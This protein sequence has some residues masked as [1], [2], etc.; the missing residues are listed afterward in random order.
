MEQ[1]L[2]VNITL[3]CKVQVS[4]SFLSIS[5][6]K[7]LVMKYMR[8]ED[9]CFRDLYKF[10]QGYLFEGVT[11]AIHYMTKRVSIVL[12]IMQKGPNNGFN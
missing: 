6:S 4:A 8:R 5:Q 12:A 11:T 2:V 10:E 1:Y 9:W 3:I 7:N